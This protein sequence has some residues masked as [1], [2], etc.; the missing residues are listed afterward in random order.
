M[1][2]MNT[3][4]LYVMNPAED[5]VLY[6]DDLTEGMMVMAESELARKH[7]D[8]DRQLR[9]NRF[10]KVTRL[11]RTP[12]V[13]GAPEQVLFIGEW[14]DGYQQAYGG[15]VTSTWIVKRDQPGGED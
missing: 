6:G 15:A 1:T 7:P 11:R 12:A 9:A 10:C 5:I 14:V 3:S 8:E 2:A 4:A 13:G